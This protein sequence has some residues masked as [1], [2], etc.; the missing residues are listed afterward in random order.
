MGSVG[1]NS[2]T[3]KA[4]VCDDITKLAFAGVVFANGTLLFELL[5]YEYPDRESPDM[6]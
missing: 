4:Y 3:V 5:V 1:Y 2:S 6:L